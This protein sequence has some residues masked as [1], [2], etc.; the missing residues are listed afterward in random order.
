MQKIEWRENVLKIAFV[1]GKGKD[2]RGEMSFLYG[3]SGETN[4][5]RADSN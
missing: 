5:C 2:L 3:G 1:K 4:L